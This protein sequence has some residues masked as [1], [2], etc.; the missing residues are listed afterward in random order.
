[1]L[2]YKIWSYI[3]FFRDLPNG[4]LV[5]E[6]ER[7]QT[8]RKYLVNEA[9]ISQSSSTDKV[10]D[11]LCLDFIINSYKCTLSEKLDDFFQ[12]SDSISF[13][14]CS[15]DFIE[16]CEYILEKTCST[17][18][19]FKRIF[20]LNS[21][22]N[23]G[24]T[25]MIKTFLKSVDE[26]DSKLTISRY[27]IV[28]TSTTVKNNEN[29]EKSSTCE[30]KTKSNTKKYM[31]DGILS[32]TIS[33][34]NNDKNYS[35]ETIIYKEPTVLLE[36]LDQSILMKSMKKNIPKNPLPLTEKDETVHP[37]DLFDDL[38]SISSDTECSRTLRSRKVLTKKIE[39]NNVY[40]S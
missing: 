37:L 38:S 7:E 4:L 3:L 8:V 2:N 19:N 28:N 17:L 24:V 21:N 11:R 13:D 1:M 23:P 27:N 22:L 34:I 14:K 35:I 15:R 32:P 30:E 26:D 18:T 6:V 12:K 16:N 20:K 5:N 31:M 33:T 40:K 39:V 36:R 10:R 25:A 9:K 29:N